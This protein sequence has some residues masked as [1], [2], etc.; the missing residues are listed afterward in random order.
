MSPLSS[1]NLKNGVKKDKL[2]VLLA[3]ETSKTISLSFWGDQAT[4]SE[5][6]DNPVIALKGVR[7]SNYGGKSLNCVEESTVLINPQIPEAKKLKEWFGK[8]KDNLSSL[9]G[10]SLDLSTGS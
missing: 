5:Y 2:T 9:V 8:Q 7:V 4:M 3:D 1:I 10:V 6:K